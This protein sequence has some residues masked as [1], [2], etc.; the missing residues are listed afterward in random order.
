MLPRARRSSGQKERNSFKRHCESSAF[1]FEGCGDTTSSAAVVGSRNRNPNVMHVG[2]SP[3]I[4]VPRSEQITE[5]PN[6]ATI[7]SNKPL[8]R[9][10]LIKRKPKPPTVP[11]YYLSSAFSNR[12][13]DPSRAA[14]C[15]AIRPRRKSI[16][17]RGWT[18]PPA[19]S[20]DH[21]GMQYT[22]CI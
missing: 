12:S 14:G 4:V 18:Q 9:S 5:R 3:F 22:Y 16:P 1:G 11:G 21:P 19:R 6:D 2:V 10:T 17:T 7:Y 13:A 20:S 8:L 15:S